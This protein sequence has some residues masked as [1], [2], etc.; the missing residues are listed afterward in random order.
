MRSGRGS[1]RCCHRGRRGAPT[2]GI[3]GSSSTGCSSACTPAARGETCRS[4]TAPGPPSPRAS[5]DGRARGSGTAS[6]RR[7][8]ATS[9]RW[10]RST[11]SS[12]AST[13]P[14]SQRTA[15]PRARRR[16]G[17]PADHALGRS[18]GGFSTKI[19]LLSDG[20][21]LPLTAE[22]SAGQ[23]HESKYVEPVLD[24]VRVRRCRAGRPRRR[25]RRLAGDKG[26]SYPRVRAA[27]RRRH[28]GAVI[29]ERDDQ[30]ERRAHRPGRK[31]QFDKAAYRQRHVIENCVGW[32]KEARGLATRYE[33][34]AVHYL[35]LVKL[36]IIRRL[37][38]RLIAPL[39]HRA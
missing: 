8:S 39:S 18:R 1:R 19:H 12:G 23:A 32:L 37:L 9:T 34:L 25:P 14:T 5:A 2:T 29:A 6:S 30:R 11:G 4:A 33:K 7:S 22:L 28:I 20:T 27:L 21:V 16:L 38:K 36:A 3:I 10:G 24:R 15:L 31:P 26:Y 17:E 13:A 35:A